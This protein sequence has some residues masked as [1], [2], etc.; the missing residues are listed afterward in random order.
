MQ[1]KRKS[2][3]NDLQAAEMRRRQRIRNW[4]ILVTVA[5]L[6]VGGYFL[7]RNMGRTSEISSVAMP[8]YSY[9][10]VTMFGEDVLYYD[11]A[12]IHCLTG[13]GKVRWS[14]PVGSGASFT[15]SDTHLVA[16]VGSTLFIVDRNGRPTYN[17]NLESTIQLARI[18]SRYAVAVVGE[19]TEPSVIIK[20]LQGAQIDIETEAYSGMLVLDAGFYGDQGQYM[21]TLAMDVYGTAINTVLNTFE[22]GKMNTGVVSLG[23][24][25]AYK[26]LFESG[27][28]RVFTTQQMYSYDYKAVQDVNDT[29]LV[30][31]WN[32]IDAWLNNRGAAHILL[33]Q[34]AQTAQTSAVNAFTEL[35]VISGTLD[36]RYTLPGECVGAAVQ[37]GSIY[38]V[39]S[40][41][42]YRCSID[43]Q[44]FYGFD[45]RL[46][47]GREIT[48]LLGL[49]TSGRAIVSAGDA[50]YSVGLPK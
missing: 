30:Y 22:V 35:R 49:T 15:V 48:G 28:L 13:T 6:A 39:A 19:N 40:N 1:G 34:T 14:F 3:L 27:K 24:N 44:R 20:D 11:G 32:M 25:L 26:V 43:S 21:W 46:P 23:K 10:D 5:V 38:A 2:M 36:R 4:M 41:A 12:S 16:W 37:N 45:P 50:V 7:L 31:G 47:E 29:L 42:L 8:C 17:E 33:A 18:G 9:Q